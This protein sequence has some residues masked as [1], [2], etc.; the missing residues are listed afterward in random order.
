VDLIREE[1][2]PELGIVAMRVEQRVREMGLVPLGIRHWAGEP[3]VI[4]LASE[5][6]NP[7][8]HRDGHPV[9]SKLAH[10]S[11]GFG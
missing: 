8:R 11:I 7:T 6:Q 10:A 5:L 1:P 4:G 2:I 9:S 3:P